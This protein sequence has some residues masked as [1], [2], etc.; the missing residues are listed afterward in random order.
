M[1]GD[2]EMLNYITSK[3]SFINSNGKYL[4]S[5]VKNEHAVHAFNKNIFNLGFHNINIVNSY[6]QNLL[7][8]SIMSNNYK[9]LEELFRFNINFTNVDSLGQNILHYCIN[10]NSI[11]CCNMILNHLLHFRQIEIIQYLIFGLDN[12]RENPI[13]TAAKYGRME[14]IYYI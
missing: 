14:I 13:F 6:Q 9:M 1:N 7:M 8:I 10:S 2:I 12:N 5:L 3:N 4:F 11:I